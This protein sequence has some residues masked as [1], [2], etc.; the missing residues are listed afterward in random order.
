MVLETAARRDWAKKKHRVAELYPNLSKG[1]QTE[2][3]QRGAL[4]RPRPDGQAGATAW[5]IVVQQ[6]ERYS[7]ALLQRVDQITWRA[8][9]DG[10]I[11]V[12]A[13]KGGKTVFNEPFDAETGIS[14][15]NIRGEQR[16]LDE[17]VGQVKA[18]GAAPTSRCSTGCSTSRAT[19]SPGG[20]SA[21]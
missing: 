14:L 7:D 13:R 20:P 2:V 19:R 18:H 4:C 5:T 15:V 6:V 17:V 1:W 11:N 21:I 9:S 3:G 8:T 16:H 12:S 10:L